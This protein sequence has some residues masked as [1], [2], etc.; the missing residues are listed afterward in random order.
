MYEIDSKLGGTATLDIIITEP[1][2]DDRPAELEEPNLR[3]DLI[4]KWYEKDSIVDFFAEDLFED[5]DSNASGYWWNTYS[6][7]KLE[8]IH[9]YLGYNFKRRKS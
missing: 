7:N 8:D 9:N 3:E 5:S 4:I 2:F 6:L 1:K